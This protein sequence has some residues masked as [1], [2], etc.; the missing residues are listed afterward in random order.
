[1]TWGL[2]ISK[3]G[4]TDRAKAISKLDISPAEVTP[5]RGSAYIGCGRGDEPLDARLFRWREC[6]AT[7][8]D[9]RHVAGQCKKENRFEG[10]NASTF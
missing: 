4:Q 10:G 9:Y 1:M 7:R 5:A 6:V 2:K 3:Y 8:L